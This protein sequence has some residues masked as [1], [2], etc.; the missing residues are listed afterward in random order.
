MRAAE[1][2]RKRPIL[3]PME[4]A[5]IKVAKLAL[6]LPPNSTPTEEDVKRRKK[7]LARVLH[8]D[9]GGGD[10]EA[11]TLLNNMANQ[12]IKLIREGKVVG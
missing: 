3:T 11:M 2:E 9:V 10:K 8:P 6:Y 5:T 4:E 7:Q 1:K 12:L